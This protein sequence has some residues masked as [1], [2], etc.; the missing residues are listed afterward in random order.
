MIIPPSFSHK[1]S[2]GGIVNPKLN[3][4]SIEQQTSR[5]LPIWL[6]LKAK[7]NCRIT[8]PQQFHTRIIKAVKKRRDKDTLFLYTLAETHKK[9]TIKY[10][11]EGSVIHFRLIIELSLYGL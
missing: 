1:E 6:E 8:A 11:I 10:K 2:E 3:T 9:H 4:M 5:Y 7:G